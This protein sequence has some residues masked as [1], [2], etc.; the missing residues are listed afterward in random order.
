MIVIQANCLERTAC[1]HH[2]GKIILLNIHLLCTCT[3]CKSVPT[4]VLPPN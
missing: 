2:N 4:L 1:F 3:V